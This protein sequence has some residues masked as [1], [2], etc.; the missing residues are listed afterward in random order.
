M[1]NMRAMGSCVVVLKEEYV[2]IPTKAGHSNSLSDI[3][4]QI[5]DRERG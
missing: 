5:P 3:A 2:L 4:V 1:D